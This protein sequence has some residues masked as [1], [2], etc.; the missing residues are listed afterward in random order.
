MLG[1]SGLCKQQDSVLS[2][3]KKTIASKL[4]VPK[5]QV[6]HKFKELLYFYKADLIQ[7]QAWCTVTALA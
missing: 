3:V 7:G 4:E 1:E 6:N 2:V 5:V